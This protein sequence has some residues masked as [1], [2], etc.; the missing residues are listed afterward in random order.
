MKIHILSLG[1]L[2]MPMN[3]L[4]GKDYPNTIE[5]NVPIYSVLIEHPDG[6]VLF[7][8]G[9]ITKDGYLAEYKNYFRFSK[10]DMIVNRLAVLGYTPEDIKYVIVSH[11]HF[12]HAGNIYLFKNAEILVSREEFSKTMLD[13]G[14]GT[15]KAIGSNEVELWVKSSLNWKLI[16]ED[17]KEVLPGITIY[18]FGSGHN[19]G[20]LAVL[21]DTQTL[22]KILISGDIAYTKEA[23]NQKIPGVVRDKK[24]YLGSID[25]VKEMQKKE[26]VEVWF[27]HDLE[28]FSM[29]KKSPKGYYE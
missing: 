10:E 6:L 24:E 5:P 17:T 29:L 16:K 20:M 26:N 7:D 2:S 8:T 15:L 11:L 13:Y 9:C 19:Y 27:G 3:L 25:K 28:Q 21:I 18:N 22:G 23:M 12:D 1:N 14:L 4:Y